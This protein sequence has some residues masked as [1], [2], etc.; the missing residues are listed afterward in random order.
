MFPFLITQVLDV[1]WGEILRAAGFGILSDLVLVERPLKV[2]P[3]E[4]RLDGVEAR[5]TVPLPC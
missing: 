4:S 2:K 1:G 5:D 3:D